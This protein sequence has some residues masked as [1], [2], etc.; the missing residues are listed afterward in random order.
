MCW[1]HQD[2]RSSL[3][4]MLFKV[5]VLENEGTLFKNL[6][7]FCGD[8]IFS[9]ICGGNKPLWGELKLYRG[10]IFI[11]TLSLFHFFR[12]SQHP[13]KW[14]VSLKNFFRKC[15]YIRSCYLLIS[16]HLLK[17]SFR[18]TSLFVLLEFLPT[19]FFK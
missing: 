13:Q 2:C 17:K 11:T 1:C 4:Q 12:Y 7:T 16:S 10:V 5:D 9:Y 18:K 19:G 3:L 6:P 8:K 15:K 14:S